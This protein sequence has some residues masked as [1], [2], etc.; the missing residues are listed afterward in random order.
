MPL[1][2]R[3]CYSTRFVSSTGS[4]NAKLKHAITKVCDEALH[5]PKHRLT[6]EPVDWNSSR[7]EQLSFS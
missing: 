5:Q 4:D 2:S 1:V 3:V 6:I 7:P